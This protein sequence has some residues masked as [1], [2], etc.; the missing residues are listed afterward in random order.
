MVA[1]EAAAAEAAL[2][3]KRERGSFVSHI[4][5]WQ[6]R[7]A[8]IG[9]ADSLPDAAIT[10]TLSARLRPTGIFPSTSIRMIL[11]SLLRT[12]RYN[13]HALGLG[14]VTRQ[15]MGISQLRGENSF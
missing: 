4:P 12:L 13:Y 2:A 8:N 10:S 9:I 14:M 11:Y 6:I 5:S 3:A 7:T 15:T 1:A